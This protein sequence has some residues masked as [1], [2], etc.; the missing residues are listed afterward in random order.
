MYLTILLY[1]Q[2]EESGFTG[3]NS[4]T[5]TYLFFFFS[6]PSLCQVFRFKRKGKENVLVSTYIGRRE[7]ER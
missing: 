5:K 2:E 3:Y 6:F 1:T 7:S 4:K